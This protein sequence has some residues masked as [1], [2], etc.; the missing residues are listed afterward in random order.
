[1]ME[2]EPPTKNRVNL[3]PGESEKY[4]VTW[5]FDL[6]KSSKEELNKLLEQTSIWVMWTTPKNEVGHQMLFPTSH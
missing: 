4:N 6:T 5:K 2:A 1:M 3:N